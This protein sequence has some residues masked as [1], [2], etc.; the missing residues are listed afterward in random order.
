MAA[1]P[2]FELILRRLPSLREQVAEQRNTLLAELAMVSE[3]PAPTFHEQQRAQFLQE[4]FSQF[5]LADV[6]QDELGNVAA[7]HPGAESDGAILLVAHLDT[8]FPDGTEHITEVQPDRVVGASVAD[9]SLGL[10]MLATLPHLLEHLGIALRSDLLL[11][12]TTRSL[13]RGNLAGLRFFLENAPLPIRTAVCVEGAPLGRLS[14]TSIGMIRGDVICR[15][16]EQHDWTRFGAASAIVTVNE[17]INRILELPLPRRPRSTVVLGEV[18]GGTAAHTVATR[19]TLGFEAR[20]ESGHLVASLLHSIGRIAQQVAAQG[21]EHV[22]LELVAR[23]HPG[24]IG[25]DHP[26]VDRSR[27]I[28]SRLG[29][30]PRMTPSTSELAALIDRRVPAI[31]I[32][33]T[34]ST[35]AGE[36]NETVAIEPMATGVTQLLGILLAIDGG[37][38]V[39]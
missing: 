34:E 16:P 11:L 35:H 38:C 7:V 28:M 12:G 39:E 21:G 1:L 2:P 5:G 15:I 24:G 14:H 31:T 6:V 32:G 29:L 22:E 9:D 33:I 20:S 4:R 26:L 30:S 37:Y 36:A 3:I 27:R 10:A 18:R 25:L 23:R 8:L 17:V 13:G 19:A